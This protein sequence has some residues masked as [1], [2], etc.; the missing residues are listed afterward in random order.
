MIRCMF[1]PGEP[2]GRRDVAIAAVLS[3]LGLVLMY[4][5]AVNHNINASYVA[6][7]VF[8]AVT[9]P[10]LWR[11]AAPLAASAGVLVALLVHVALFGTITRCG[12]VF[13]VVWVL[14]FAAGAR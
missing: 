9:V 10:V 6:M 11:R 5:D 7:P 14:V 1:V 2:I 8:L 3:L 12:V 4:D 13:P